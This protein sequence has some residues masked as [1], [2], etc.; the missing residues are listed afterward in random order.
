LETQHV[1]YLARTAN[2][3]GEIRHSGLYTEITARCSKGL[4]EWGR[5]ETIY[6][7]S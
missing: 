5:T 2:T 1:V 6:V 3:K 7:H 4:K